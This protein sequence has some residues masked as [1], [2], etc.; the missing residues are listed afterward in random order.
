MNKLHSLA[1]RLFA[2][3]TLGVMVPLICGVLF[4]L[5]L[6]RK[7][8]ESE[9]AEYHR[10]TLNSLAYSTQDA[11]YA[12]SP[13]T[14]LNVAQ[15][16]IRDKRILRIEVYSELYGMFLVNIAKPAAFNPSHPL[17]LRKDVVL[18]KEYLGYVE[19]TVDKG[20]I[21]PQIAKEQK[22]IALLF[23]TILLLGL[24][25]VLPVAY[26]VILRPIHRLTAQAKLLT[27]GDLNSPLHWKGK[28]ELSILGQTFETMRQSL[29][30]SFTRIKELA[31]TDELT[32]IPNRRAFMNEARN[33][34]NLSERYGWPFSLAIADLDHFKTINDTYGHG[35]GDDVL[36][37]FAALVQ[38]NIRRSDLFAR[39]GGEEFI[40]LMPKTNYRDAREVADKLRRAVE[41]HPFAHGERVTISLG[42]VESGKGSSLDS[43]FRDADTALYRAKKEG[44]NRV[45]VFSDSQP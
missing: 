22:K 15:M 29:N 6:E 41:K 43:L 35:R 26:V 7:Q 21:Q 10:E 44:R 4:G 33:I 8:L 27:T 37:D 36:R 20:C 19:L 23:L 39:I 3:L 16:I 42:I 34:Y 14:A 13:R 32:G 40:L 12:F 38:K 9:L 11:L 1:F 24:G 30:Q 2:A 25:I 18:E 5:H 45:E 17:P 31:V 28:D